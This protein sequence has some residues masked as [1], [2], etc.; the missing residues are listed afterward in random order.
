MSCQNFRTEIEETARGASLGERAASHLA[1]CEECR[2][3]SDESEKLRGLISGLARVEAPADFEFRLRARLARAE[4]AS[5]AR[6]GWR[7]F[8]PGAAWVAVAGCLV[9]ALGLFVHFRAPHETNQL[10][11]AHDASANSSAQQATASV[12]HEVK[13]SGDGEAQTV[14]AKDTSDGVNVDETQD[15]TEASADLTGRVRRAPRRQR[16]IIP[17]EAVQQLAEAQP[18]ARSLGTNV[19]GEG[20]MKI[21]TA[22]PIPLPGTTQERPLEALFTD[23]RGASHAVSVDPVTFGARGLPA[24]RSRVANVKYTQVQGVW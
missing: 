7:G 14:A 5:G 3:F 9:L 10:A 11:A 13:P 22:S 6:A 4:D 20:E 16:F 12:E 21:Y 1:S 24:Q 2:T 17:R 15:S 8:V 23:A 19:L 18:D